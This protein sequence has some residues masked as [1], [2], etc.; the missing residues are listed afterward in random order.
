M[1]TEKFLIVDANWR[2]IMSKIN[3]NPLVLE[4]TKHKNSLDILREASKNLEVV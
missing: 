3:Q 4:F 1:E 2:Q